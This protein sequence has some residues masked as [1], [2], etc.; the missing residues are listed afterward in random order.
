MAHVLGE[1]PLAIA[2]LRCRRYVRRGESI[3][4]RCSRPRTPGD[5]RDLVHEARV[6]RRDPGQFYS[7][8]VAIRLAGAGAIC[9]T[10]AITDPRAFVA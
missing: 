9:R 5:L 4:C 6:M 10:L 3:W 1:R 2:G 7:A 8:A